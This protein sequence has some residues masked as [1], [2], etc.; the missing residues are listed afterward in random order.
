MEH[1]TQSSRAG[2]QGAAADLTGHT[3]GDFL[4]LRRLGSGGMGQVYLAQQ[5]SLKRKVALKLLRHDLAADPVALQRFKKEAE[6]VARVTHANIVQVYAIGEHDGL[7]YMALEYVEGRNLKEYLARKGPPEVPVALSIMRQ[8]AA[9]LQRASESGIIHR[10][11]KPENILLNRKGEVKVADFGLSRVHADNQP[12]LNLTRSGVVMG[13]PLYMS[14]EQVQGQPVDARTDI[15]SLGVTCYHLLAGHPPYMGTN[16]FD[17]A[18]KHV[19]GEPAPLASIRPDLPAELCAVVQKMMARAPADR[20]QTG[21][22]L[23]RELARLRDSLAGGPGVPYTQAVPLAAIT[24]VAPVVTGGSPTGTAVPA[25]ASGSTPSLP[26]AAPRWTW[27]LWPLVASVVLALF[28]GGGVAWW[29]RQHGSTPAAGSANSDTGAVDALFSLAKREQFLKEAVEVYAHP[30]DATQVRTGVSHFLELG[31]FYL[32]GWRLDEADQLFRRL[33]NMKEVR[34]YQ[35]LGRLGRAVVLGLQN[36][37]AESDRLFREVLVQGE[38][39]FLPLL[40]ANPKLCEWVTRSLE[41]DLTNAPQSFPPDLARALKAG[42]LRGLLPVRQD[43][44]GRVPPK[45]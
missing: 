40:Q 35:G 44:L 13:T 22:D 2:E 32:E 5:L 41:Y 1:S 17:V 43:L 30:A 39:Q 20:Y 7:H 14:P 31:L 6:A 19:Q 37:T 36:Q 38:P 33:E 18:M 24:G 21:K 12:P 3:L 10:D 23:L 26:A 8:V 45:P 15:Y 11:I 25:R 29:Q 16:P 9:A 4:I 28:A 27:P 34:E 42:R